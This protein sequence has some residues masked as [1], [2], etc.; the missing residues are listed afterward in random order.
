MQKWVAHLAEGADANGIANDL[1][2]FYHAKN[3]EVSPDGRTIRFDADVNDKQ[4]VEGAFS[5]ITNIEEAP[6]SADTH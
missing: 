6:A 3:V 5:E 2:D 1:R 4:S